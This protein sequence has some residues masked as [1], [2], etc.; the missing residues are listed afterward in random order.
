MTNISKEKQ[1][2]KITDKGIIAKLEYENKLLRGSL[3]VSSVIIL[4]LVST[5]TV[6]V[7][8]NIRG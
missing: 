6:M 2:T 5:L 1:V 4:V 8:S 7:L 3:A